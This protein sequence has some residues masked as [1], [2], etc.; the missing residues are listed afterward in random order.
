MRDIKFIFLHCTATPQSTTVES[1]LN[2]WSKVKGWNRVGYHYLIEPDGN[3]NK[4][5][6][7]EE[8]VWGVKGFN[9]RSVHISYIG[10]VDEVNKP[11]DNRTTKQIEKQIELLKELCGRYPKA[12]ILGHNEVNNNKACPSFDVQSWLSSVSL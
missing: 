10:G 11:L 4:L 12:Q 5:E 9:S 1:I 2:Y 3:V 7:L 6:E 8:I